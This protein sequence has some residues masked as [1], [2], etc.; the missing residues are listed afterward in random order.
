[1]GLV[2]MKFGNLGSYKVL[3]AHVFFAYQFATL[4]N[5]EAKKYIYIYI[6]YPLVDAFI[7]FSPLLDFVLNACGEVNVH[8]V[9][10]E[11]FVVFLLLETMTLYWIIWGPHGENFTEVRVN[12]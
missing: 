7:Y 1:M 12:D 11:S 5:F 8:F 9:L 2:F 6:F 3:N 10:F 4:R